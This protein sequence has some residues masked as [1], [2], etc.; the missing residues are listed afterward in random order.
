MVLTGDGGDEL[1][2]GYT[3]YQHEK[4]ASRYQSLPR[5]I[6]VTFPKVLSCIPIGV[7]S[8][9]GY[10]IKRAQI[11]SATANMGFEERY[12]NKNLCADLPTIKTLLTCEDQFPVEQFLG[13]LMNRCQYRDPF[14]KMMFLNFKLTLP[15]DM[16]AKVDRMSMAYSLETRAPFL[17][18]RLIEFMARVHKNVKMKNYERKTVLRNSI[19]KRL[20]AKL[21]QA[22][23]KGFSV[24]LNKW[25]S[26]DSFVES[27]KQLQHPMF[28][29]DAITE[30][31]AKNKQGKQAYGNLLWMLLVLQNNLAPIS[32]KMN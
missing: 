21:L 18:H 19:A 8:R 32:L 7:K 5:R 6:K 23:K 2:S 13:D 17:D 25:F 14:Y 20:P 30:I 10:K 11:I 12:L 16:L 15:D 29:Q 31:I 28:Q 24:P 9:L 3:L 26:D 4:F 22:P 27:L 1:L